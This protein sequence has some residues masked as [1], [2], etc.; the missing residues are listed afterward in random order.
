M[1]GIALKLKILFARDYR[2]KL[3]KERQNIRKAELSELLLPTTS[4]ERLFY[5]R[6]QTRQ[7]KSAQLPGRK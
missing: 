3:E 5:K 4:M 7:D 6:S 2:M 1:D